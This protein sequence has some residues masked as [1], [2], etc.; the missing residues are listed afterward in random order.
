MVKKQHNM[1][2]NIEKRSYK[3]LKQ[4]DYKEIIW[5]QSTKSYGYKA[6]N[7]TVTK[8]KTTWLQNTD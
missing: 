8:Y 1:G 7:D 2:K 4:H 6:Q 5:L 3:K